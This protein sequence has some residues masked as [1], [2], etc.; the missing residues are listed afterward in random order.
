M[1]LVDEK[2][3]RSGKVLDFR[4]LDFKV[5]GLERFSRGQPAHFLHLVGEFCGCCP[6]HRKQLSAFSL[7][8]PQHILHCLNHGFLERRG[9]ARIGTR[10]AYENRGG[11][12][13]NHSFLGKQRR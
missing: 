1:R 3:I 9:G 4:V 12:V 2:A 7:D 10:L 5:F 11:C 6:G 8:A 13:L